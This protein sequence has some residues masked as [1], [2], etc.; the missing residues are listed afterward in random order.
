MLNHY[1]LDWE[2]ICNYNADAQTKMPVDRP[3]TLDIS[4][5]PKYR[6]KIVPHAGK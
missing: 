1:L 4:I 5:P 6:G 3:N 2:Q